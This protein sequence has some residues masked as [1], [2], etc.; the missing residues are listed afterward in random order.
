M[1]SNEELKNID[2]K[3]NSLL[4]P[5]DGEVAD[6]LSILHQ[7]EKYYLYKKFDPQHEDKDW[8]NIKVRA[9]TK[10]ETVDSL[11]SF[12]SNN[13]QYEKYFSTDINAKKPVLTKLYEILSE[14]YFTQFEND[15]LQ[16]IER[17]ELLVLACLTGVSGERSPEVTMIIGEQAAWIS[18]IRTNNV[19]EKL[20]TSTYKVLIALLG[21]INQKTDIDKISYFIE[22]SL[23]DLKGI[24]ETILQAEQFDLEDGFLIGTFGN[25]IHIVKSLSEYLYNGKTSN[26]EKI[27]DIVRDYSY[28]AIELTK[29]ISETNIKKITYH[30]RRSLNQ[31]CDNSIWNLAEINP[32]FKAFFEKSVHNSENFFLTLLPS[33]RKSLYQVLSAKKSIVINMP[34]S[35]G[36]SLLAEM[37]ILFTIQT[38]T[39]GNT[40]PTIAY[41]VPT[42]ALINQVKIR[43]KRQFGDEYVIE[44]VLPFY[45]DDSLEE[46]LLKKYPHIHVVVTTPEKLDFLIRNERPAVKNL[47]LVILDEAHNISSKD[48]GSKFELLLSIIKQKKTDVNYLLLSPFIEKR[49]AD[50][51]A[52]WL[53]ETNEKSASISISWSPTKQF[54]G[55]NTLENGKSESYINYFPT[56]RNQIIRDDVRIPLNVNLN[57]LKGTLGEKRIDSPTKVIGLLTK[58]LRLGESTLVFCGG[59]GTSQKLAIKA[60]DYFSQTGLLPNI[61]NDASIQRC[62]TI[63]KYESKADDPLIECLKYGVA[64]H[65]SEL[66]GLV[67]EELESL[68]SEGK[69]KLICATPTLAQGMNF[70]ISNVIFD[71]LSL[72]RGAGNNSMDNPTFWNIAG[73]AG[74]AFMDKEGHI[75]IGFTGSNANT[76]TQT[77]KYIQNDAKEIISSLTSF[78]DILEDDFDFNFKLLNS[79]PAASNFLQYLNHI[80]KVSHKYDLDNVDSN[81]IRTILNNSFYYQQIS[82]KQGFLETERKISE[83]SSKYVAYL[84]GQ[85]KGSLTLADVFGISNISLNGLMGAVAEYKRKLSEQYLDA[86][87]RLLASTVI[88]D[89]KDV[90]SLANIIKII[91]LVPELKVSLW[92]KKGALDVISIAKLLMGWVN[93]KSISAI[94]GEVQKDDQTIQQ[95]I[96]FCNSYIN[97]KLKNYLPWGLNMYQS[98][99]NDKESED[100]KMLPSYVYYGVNDKESAIIASLGIPRFLIKN[101]KSKVKEITNNQVITTENINDVK[102]A[103]KKISDFNIGDSNTEKVQIKKIIDSKL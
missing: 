16:D 97:G 39:Y 98:L 74:R 18:N 34:T 7:H 84:K 20:K 96:G 6:L 42:N 58:Y 35:S 12:L 26:N 87:D 101:V 31:I 15:K 100:A 27:K 5:T 102:V 77:K 72:G 3:I 36:K 44:S 57:T 46:E 88:L 79:H 4:S 2:N 66:S 68:I 52:L 65:H 10:I 43:L 22:E 25:I 24:Q 19:T 40:K 83:F 50:E 91:S 86:E 85:N 51:L 9:N 69:V 21:K 45:E 82:F 1:L 75:I 70:P 62:I 32:V 17:L 54:V 23:G 48:R 14:L 76:I 60:K 90:D 56:T 94:A 63:I 92:D 95:A 33:Q 55:C 81:K 29:N 49:N 64:F 37:L 78:F 11:A 61:S 53:G 28:N 13:A 38:Q 41:V 80:L 89:N 8:E 59:T 103:L 93:G 73:R 67:K 99:T 47:K 30:I 71:T